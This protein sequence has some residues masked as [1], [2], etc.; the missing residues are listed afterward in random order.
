MSR[1]HSSVLQWLQRR[2]S[3]LVPADSSHVVVECAAALFLLIEA[4][5]LLWFWHSIPVA[6]QVI[7]WLQWLAVLIGLRVGG[8]F[9]LFGPVLYYDLVRAARRRRQ[10]ILRCVY[11]FLL[12]FLICWVYMMWV[13]D[14]PGGQLTAQQ[15]PLFASSFFYMFMVVQFVAV[16]ILTPAYTAG[17]IAEEKD[18]KTLEFMLATDLRNREIVLSKLAS[19]L[20]NLTLLLL[21]GVPILSALQFFGGVDPNLTIAGF[22]ATVLTMCSLAGLGIFCSVHARKPRDAISLTFLAFGAYLIVS[23]F[24]WVG[25]YIVSRMGVTLTPSWIPATLPQDL[26]EWLAAGNIIVALIRLAETVNMGGGTVDKVLPELLAGYAIFHGLVAIGMP[27]WATARLR[28]V[29]MSEHETRP[30]KKKMAALPTRVIRRPRVGRYPMLWKEVFAEPGMRLLWLGR[31]AVALVVLGSFAPAILIFYF[32]IIDPPGGQVPSLKNLGEG[33]M[34][35][36]R[37]VGPV[38]ASLTLLAVGIRAAG[39]I[40]GERDK[41]T[42]DEL[43][44]S[45]LTSQ[46]IL[47]AKWFGS[48]TS[49]RAGWLWLALLWGLA[50]LTGGMNP[51]AVV[52]LV[53]A[54]LAY[55]AVFAG[56]GVWFS[57]TCS[58]SLRSTLWTLSTILLVSAG[59]WIVMALFVYTPLAALGGRSRVINDLTQWLMDLEIGQTPP[60]VFGFLAFRLEDFEIAN[61]YF[62]EW[63]A[64]VI[65]CCLWGILLWGGAAGV[66]YLVA[67]LRFRALTNRQAVLQP[68]VRLPRTRSAPR[69]RPGLANEE[70]L[71]VLPAESGNGDAQGVREKVGEPPA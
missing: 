69:Q 13:M 64:K 59:H 67:S 37:G 34:V 31:I 26:A 61:R 70:R 11:A 62:T 39:S 71:D 9:L 33:M 25:V 16:V 21:T 2:F 22:A 38:A 41:H 63:Y 28:S 47:F 45:P 1:P 42:F 14:R 10:I 60:L 15:M 23:T 54:W 4:A 20:A 29:A 7:L 68:E 32:T 49:V 24:A 53:A 35:W 19:R 57:M 40:S 27:L 56:I 3:W 46:A 43:L 65:G 12:L 17:A 30:R 36:V 55:A 8:F 18:R 5:A 6:A 58:T 50:V 48:I 52:P 44:T 66:V 51:F